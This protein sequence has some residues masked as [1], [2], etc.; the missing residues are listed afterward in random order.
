MGVRGYSVVVA[1]RHGSRSIALRNVTALDVSTGTRTQVMRDG[2]IGLGAGVTIGFVL[3]AA[4]FEEPDLF[5]GG[6]VEAGALVGAMFGVVGMVAG[7]VVGALHSTDRWEP[8]DLPV[9][10]AIGPS[11]S[12]GVR[13]SFSRAF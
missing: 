4:T 12:G 6:A 1:G 5:V 9:K 2:L 10:A 7:G 13:L 3:G 11:R 8:R